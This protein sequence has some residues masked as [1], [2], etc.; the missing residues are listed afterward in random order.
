MPITLKKRTI[1]PKQS[2]VAKFGEFI[3][4][5]LERVMPAEDWLR[6]AEQ[7]KGQAKLFLKG[8]GEALKDPNPTEGIVEALSKE[9]KPIEKIFNT[10]SYIGKQKEKAQKLLGAVAYPLKQ[11]ARP[12][13][14]I[15]EGVGAAIEK[16]PILPAATKGFFV[17]E[18]AKTITS[19]IP[20]QKFE[21]GEGIVKLIPRAVTTAIEE[22]ALYTL[23]YGGVIPKIAKTAQT[24]QAISRLER[25]GVKF[26]EGLSQGQKAW[27]IQEATRQ[28]P[29][30]G[31]AIGQVIAGGRELYAGV[32][33]PKFKTGDIVRLGKEAA[34]VLRISGGKAILGIGG[35]EITAKLSEIQPLR[36]I[37]EQ[38]GGVWKGISPT[39]PAKGKSPEIE[40]IVSFDDP[41]TKST[42]S[43][44]I[45]KVTPENVRRHIAESRAEFEPKR[46]PPF[47]IKG[48]GFTLFKTPAEQRAAKA[49][50]ELLAQKEQAKITRKIKKRQLGL[51]K[52]VEALAKKMLKP[53]PAG[54]VKAITRETTG[55]I[56]VSDLIRKDIAFKEVLRK[57]E[58]VGAREFRVG[59]E[60][61]REEMAEKYDIIK[62]MQ[63]YK[64]EVNKLVSDIDRLP[65]KNLPLDY[66]EKINEIKVPFDLRK[67]STRTLARRD[68]M[69]Q[70]V[71]KMKEQGE[72]IN[73]PQEKL[74]MLEKV[75]LNDMTIDELRDIH[76][77]ITR[78]YHQGQLKNKL[79]TSQRGREFDAVKSEG[80]ATITQG[81]G[82]TEDTPFIK[83]LRLQNRDLT[84]RSLEAVKAYVNMHLRPEVMIGGL[85][86]FA[87]GINTE[88]IWKPMIEAENAK[89]IESNK[90]KDIIMKAHEGMDI[91]KT[92]TKKYNVGRFQGM[93]KNNAMFIYANSFNEANRL[94]LEGSGI[95]D[96]DLRDI[97]EFLTPQEKEA[98]DKMIRFY[99]EVQYPAV[100]EVYSELEG[101]RLGKEDNYFPID[102]LEDISYNKELEKNILQRAYV[103]RPGVSRGFTKERITSTKG[104][105]DFDYFG[106]I[107]RN[108]QKVEHYKAFAKPI[109][110]VNKYLSN[111]EVR[112]AIKQRFGDSYYNQLTKWLKDVSFGGDK[113][114]MSAIDLT[115]RWVRTNYAVSV[116]GLN[117]LTM[118]KQP[119]SYLQGAEMAGKQAVL[120]ATGQFLTNPKK[121]ID[122]VKSKSPMMKYR[123]FTQERELREIVA[124]RGVAGKLGQLRG[125]QKVREVSMTPILAAD[126]ATTTC[127]W[128]G[129]YNDYIKKGFSEAD[130]IG[131]ADK[132]VR[133]T[134]PMAT[135]LQLPGVFRGP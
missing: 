38:A 2:V 111:K 62:T 109:R 46:L 83:S 67:R 29:K 128:L 5:T 61:G 19:R 52:E 63:A 118:S 22:L 131:W 42:L 51:E 35:K 27:L 123:G 69:R 81:K 103:R 110:D 91:G 1:T 121:W 55:Q 92:M 101:V 21:L 88:V 134:Q 114:A 93:T 57:T 10:L 73:I 72:E 13:T 44:E 45:S 119:V 50:P 80:I 68:S 117:L 96:K 122:F 116:L 36:Q 87:E 106:T 126:R 95:T 99:D 17:P 28:N 11:I 14:A 32:P 102:R 9:K 74:D 98:V 54:K 79:L 125:Y 53:L 12:I 113:S 66:K 3:T 107:Y 104:F 39:I 18:Q 58:Q 135:V 97:S 115:A 90:T 56:K 108:W 89:L 30:L 86:N 64:A 105:S 65:T 78:L 34:K 59:R 82:I 70:F 24:N 8:V 4:P 7:E 60:F 85:D 48:E 16:K 37:V 6:F 132:V 23:T 71:E 84:N 25:A 40:G 43:L 127:V 133:R 41:Q 77:T 49:A 124:Q 130:A 15:Q 75:T 26:A 94:H 76:E 33:V 20:Y 129:A 112:A 47:G 100:D 31:T 120:N